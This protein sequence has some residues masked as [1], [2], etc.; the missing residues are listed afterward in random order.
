MIM[1]SLRSSFLV[2]DVVPGGE[3]E[4]PRMRCK[5]LPLRSCDGL[6]RCDLRHCSGTALWR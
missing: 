3:F 2:V 4:R 5:P 1:M 6:S